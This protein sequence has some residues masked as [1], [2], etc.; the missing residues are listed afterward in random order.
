MAESEVGSVAGQEPAPP[1]EAALI[2]RRRETLTLPMSRRQAAAQAGI[3]PSQWSD[4]ERGSKRAGTGV[5]VPVQATARTLAMMANAIGVT[6]D[7][8]AAAGREDAARE[9]RDTA[10]QKRLRERLAAIPGL[11]ALAGNASDLARGSELLPL[12]ARG[13]DAIEDSKLP[14]RT[15]HELA[16]LFTSNLLHDATRRHDELILILRLAEATRPRG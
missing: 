14:A 7:E 13:L 15:K 4:V 11:G 2:R 9:L 1:P 10:S 16:A 3:S 8:L 6:A 12:V 5:T